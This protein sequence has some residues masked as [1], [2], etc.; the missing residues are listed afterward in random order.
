MLKCIAVANSMTKSELQ[1]RV[2]ASNATEPSTKLANNSEVA[3]TAR[4]SEA[5]VLIVFDDFIAGVCFE[6]VIVIEIECGCC[7]CVSRG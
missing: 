2:N 4:W 5:F 3:N 1:I 6:H 7:C